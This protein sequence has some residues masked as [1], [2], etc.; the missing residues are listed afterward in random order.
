MKAMTEH[1]IQKASL[2]RLLVVWVFSTLWGW[3]GGVAVAVVA[4]VAVALTGSAWD[5]AVTALVGVGAGVFIVAVERFVA[6]ERLREP[7]G[8]GGEYLRSSV[9]EYVRGVSGA[10]VKCV[11]R[12]ACAEAPVPARL[13]PASSSP[14]GG[15]NLRRSSPSLEESMCG[16]S[17]L[18][19]CLYHTAVS[20]W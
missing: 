7:R 5:E 16:S 6:V 8:P 12:P 9:F 17:L 15:A 20:A 13:A 10:G 1:T 11:D 14:A 2:I 19:R 3:L 18:M 4:A